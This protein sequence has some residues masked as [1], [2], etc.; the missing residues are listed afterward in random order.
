[1]PTFVAEI[2]SVAP[3][4]HAELRRRLSERIETVG[5]AVGLL[6]EWTEASHETHAELS[7]KY[8]TAKN[9]ARDDVRE[10]TSEE[11]AAALSAADLVSHPAVSDRTKRQ[12]S[13]YATKL[14]AFLDEERSYEGARGELLDALGAELALYERLTAEL[15]IDA[16]SVRDA[17]QAIARFARDGSLGGADTT[18]A[19]VLL[20]SAAEESSESD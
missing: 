11:T 7:S 2:Q 13:E 14:H 16:A 17:Q 10:A 4:D 6:E 3:D 5:D 1:M 8:E 9:L 20:E 15:G 19:D 12:L 18:A